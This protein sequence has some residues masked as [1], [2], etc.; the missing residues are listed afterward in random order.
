M[1][2]SDKRKYPRKEIQLGILFKNG[3]EWFPATIR[4]LSEK[5]IAF[6]S[7]V[8]LKLGDMCHIYLSESKEMSSSELKGLVV[9]NEE[10]K[11]C[12][13]TKYLIGVDL[14]DANDQYVSDVQT[15]FQGENDDSN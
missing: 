11:E 6:E 3:M 9:R 14:M 5:G 4:D 1:D 7:E 15:L 12:S 10:I 8:D 2:S 13:P